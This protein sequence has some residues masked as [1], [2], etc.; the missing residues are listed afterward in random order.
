MGQNRKK[1][2]FY[3]HDLEIC[4]SYN[5]LRISGMSVPEGII[6]NFVNFNLTKKT[7]EVN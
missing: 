2:T 5:P 4:F 7:N 3:N 1:M 6:S